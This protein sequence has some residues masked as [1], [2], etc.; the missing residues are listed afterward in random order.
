MENRNWKDLE[1]Q[2]TKPR[3]ISSG[4]IQPSVSAADQQFL[5]SFGAVISCRLGDVERIRGLV[6]G[7][8]ARIV[9]QTVSNGPLFLL[10]AGQVERALQGDVSALAEIHSKKTRRVKS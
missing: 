4:A 2:E 8:G 1:K 6:Q 9:F 3:T 7:T 10:R 5:V